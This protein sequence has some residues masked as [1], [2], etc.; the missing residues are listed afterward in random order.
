[1]LEV[2]GDDECMT[3]RLCADLREYGAEDGGAITASVA[4][5]LAAMVRSAVAQ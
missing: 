5:D 4:G 2:I 1:M 3:L